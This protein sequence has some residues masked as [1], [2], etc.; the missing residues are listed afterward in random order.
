MLDDM[1]IGDMVI[2]SSSPIKMHQFC[3]DKQKAPYNHLNLS[4]LFFDRDLGMGPL[5]S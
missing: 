4:S 1:L 2:R 5:N 3:P